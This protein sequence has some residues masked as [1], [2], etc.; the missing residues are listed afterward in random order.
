[1]LFLSYAAAVFILFIMYIFKQYGAHTEVSC[2]VPVDVEQD[3][4]LVTLHVTSQVASILYVPA[5]F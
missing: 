5:F 2:L 1:M 4:H 3:H